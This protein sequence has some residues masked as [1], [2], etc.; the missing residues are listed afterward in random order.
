MDPVQR[1]MESFVEKLS[2]MVG[3]VPTDDILPVVCGRTGY[4]LAYGQ[5]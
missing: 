5:S 4:L 3:S 2:G 1:D